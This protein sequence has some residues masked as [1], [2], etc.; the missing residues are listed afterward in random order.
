MAQTIQLPTRT[1]IRGSLTIIESCLPF[2]IKRVYYIYAVPPGEVRG[3]HSHRVTRQ[4]FVAL[5]GS[6]EFHID[7]GTK[8]TVYRLE[9]P[10]ACLIL[11]PH[12]WHEIRGFKQGT[13]LLALASHA[14]DPEDY[15][16]EPPVLII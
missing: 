4:A 7:D 8:K 2:E 10:S 12:E 3:G 14:Y 5:G 16:T 9:S 13:I 15:V 1:D 11:E 6:C